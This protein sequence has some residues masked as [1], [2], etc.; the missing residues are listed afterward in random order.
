MS[1]ILDA[2]KKSEAQRQAQQGSA[3]N[4]DM[5]PRRER[6][7]GLLYGML[8]VA[9]ILLGIGIFRAGWLDFLISK[10]TALVADEQEN[11]PLSVESRETDQPAARSDGPAI[12]PA[13]VDAKPTLQ[14]QLTAQAPTMDPT[15]TEIDEPETG[16]T[17][18]AQRRVMLQEKAAVEAEPAVSIGSPHAPREVMESPVDDRVAEV[19]VGD[20][21]DEDAAP[22]AENRP[23]GS[24]VDLE[25]LPLVEVLGADSRRMTLIERVVNMQVYSENPD[26]R[27][28]LIDLR[29]HVEGDAIT[30]DVVLEK[31]LADSMIVSIDDQRY[32]W[33][34]RP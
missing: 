11:D 14:P 8:C 10:D 25:S 16:P 34:P 21:R 15:V 7:N 26:K 2:L 33:A 19:V 1:T 22:P 20:E 30:D 6:S 3:S 18:L 24:E 32:V 17:S 27:F 23:S 29:R 5:T 9:A 12:S 4:A 31:I 13:P 28:V